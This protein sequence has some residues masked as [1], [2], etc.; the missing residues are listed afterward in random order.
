MKIA[1]NIFY[2]TFIGL[3]IIAGG[4]FVASMTK[5]PGGI[6]MKI[7]QSGSMQPSIPVGALIF[8]KPVEPYSV[9]DVVTFMESPRSEAPTTHRIVSIHQENGHDVFVTKGDANED[10]DQKEITSR[11][12]LGKVF[13][14]VPS[15][16]YV[17]D[18]ARQPLGFALLIGLPAFLIIV[19]ELANIF[20]AVVG[21]RRKRRSPSILNLRAQ[22]MQKKNVL[23]DRRFPTDDI[24]VPKESPTRAGGYT[25]ALSLIFCIAITSITFSLNSRETLSYFRDTESSSGNSFMAAASFPGLTSFASSGSEVELEETP[26]P[27]LAPPA[28]NETPET[29]EETSGAEAA[30]SEETVQAED[31]RER[32]RE[33]RDVREERIEEQPESPE[34]ASP[35]AEKPQEEPSAE[36]SE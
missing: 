13:L 23:Y 25:H 3:L 24:L 20:Q 15:A 18:F 16:G 7:V 32:E 19:S 5:I 17:L 31:A 33:E 30:L 6:E 35:P 8:L 28:E 26:A 21:L 2:G 36:I 1:F 12:V 9:G 10:A 34:E 27:E 4:L 22:R 11:D 29:T 14:S